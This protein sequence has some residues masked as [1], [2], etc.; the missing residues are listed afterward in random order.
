[1]DRSIVIGPGPCRLGGIRQSDRGANRNF[2]EWVS[3]VLYVIAIG[4][5]FFNTVVSCVAYCLVAAIGFVPDR[6]GDGDREA[7]R[8]IPLL[9]S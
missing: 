7:T 4:A 8:I 5:A 2:K 6:A 3:T 1:V 9:I